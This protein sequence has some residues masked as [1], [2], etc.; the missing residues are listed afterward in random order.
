MKPGEISAIREKNNKPR[1]IIKITTLLG[2]DHKDSVKTFSSKPPNF[3]PRDDHPNPLL[4]SIRTLR[5]DMK[6]TESIPL[7]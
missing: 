4:K 3:L 5:V 7:A 1:L 2:K 6:V